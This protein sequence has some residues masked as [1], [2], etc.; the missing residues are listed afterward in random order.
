M[1][2]MILAGYFREEDADELIKDPVFHTILDKGS[3]ASQPTISGFFHRMDE[4]TL[5]PFLEIQRLLRKSIY[6]IKPPE[7]ILLD[8]D[9]TLLEAY[10][11]QEGRAFN[12]HYQRS[13]YHS[14][15]CYDGITG[16]LIKIE[17][18]DECSIVVMGLWS[19]SNR[20]RMNI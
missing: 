19:F 15:L 14:L 3:L 12:Y 4:D 13:G 16:D 11:K 7:A 17:L 9:S 20:S 18:R 2:Y 5:H 8:V 1:I 6:Q 10:G